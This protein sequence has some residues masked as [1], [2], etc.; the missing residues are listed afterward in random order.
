MVVASKLIPAR[1]PI[2]PGAVQIA[3]IP[4]DPLTQ[5]GIVTDPKQLEGK[6]LAIPVS[7]GQPIYKNM[8]ASAAGQSGFSILGPDETVAPDSE[9][10][11][12]ISITIP[13]DR[14]V[15]GLLVAGQSIDIFM[16]A[17]IAVPVTN[18]PT[19][20]YY[21]DLVTKITYQDMVI[22][23]RAGS[24]YILKASLAVSE[25]INHMLATGTVQ[26]SAAL[27]P[28]QDVRFV[29]VS[30]LGATTNRI[31]EKYGLPFPKIY[32]A[33]SATIP[34]QPPLQTPTPPPTLAPP[35]AKPRPL[36][37]PPSLAAALAAP[38]AA[39]G[40]ASDAGRL[41]AGATISAIEP[42]VSMTRVAGGARRVHE[43]ALRGDSRVR[44]ASAAGSPRR[45]RNGAPDALALRGGRA[46]DQPDLVAQVGESPFDELD[47]LDHDRWRA[48]S[49]LPPPWPRG[50]VGGPRDGRW[51]RAAASAPESANTI[52]PS[53]GR[54]SVPSVAQHASAER[55]DDRLELRA[56]R[57]RD[58]LARH[59]GPRR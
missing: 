24:Q 59:A 42:D 36:R 17:T 2:L 53:A 1:T 32:P 6:V 38:L 47:R 41:D 56:A 28:D 50:F 10:W 48:G 51:P 52:R 21:S 31:L 8:I 45:R 18:Q 49:P 33:P 26:F 54:S 55:L 23:E 46:G 12:A 57:W 34:P 16:T 13:D 9:I 15:A 25:E 44:I 22:L 37:Q 19:G 58:L 29:D 5:V 11:R 4:L 43:V 20:I 30:R 27:R 35:T 14:A 40:T 39:V 7:V 3:E